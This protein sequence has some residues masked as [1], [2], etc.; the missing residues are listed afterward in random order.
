MKKRLLI[1]AGAMMSLALNAQTI[2][3]ENFET[4]NA[5]L[6]SGDNFS[7]FVDISTNVCGEAV[8]RDLNP[9]DS[10]PTPFSPMVVT[11][12]DETGSPIFLDITNNQKVT[13]GIRAAAGL[14]IRMNYVSPVVVDGE[15][16][17]RLRDNSRQ[18]V[19]TEYELEELVFD[20]TNTTPRTSWDPTMAQRLFIE[21]DPI[22]GRTEFSGGLFYV[23]YIVIGDVDPALITPSVCSGTDDTQFVFG[24]GSSYY[25]NEFTDPSILSFSGMNLNHLVLDTVAECGKVVLTDRDDTVAISA[26]DPILFSTRDAN[27]S[28]QDIDMTGNTKVIVRAKAIGGDA[29]I[30]VDLRSTATGNST[31]G[32][33]ARI[34]R[35][36]P[37]GE[38]T[39]AEYFF[40]PSQL[41]DIDGNDVDI[42]SVNGINMSFGQDMGGIG[43]D[44]IIFDFVSFGEGPI[45]S[46]I[47]CVNAVNNRNEIQ[48]LGFYPN[49]VGSTV[50]IESASRGNLTV[51]NQYG[52][53]VKEVKVNAPSE[54][55]SLEEL[56]SG[57]YII[58]LTTDSGQI[59]TN[60]FVKD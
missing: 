51:V 55:I 1:V 38:W 56:E 40:F 3:T 16:T 52:T 31:N 13:M 46:D 17:P 4:G 26:T 45:D 9:L 37:Q 20:F 11:F 29:S 48:T 60:N 6:I 25:V 41:K 22:S 2:Y 12:R 8:I 49:P 43:A 15:Q 44:S 28:T 58:K 14:Q 53:L 47:A 19:Q 34:R 42:T 39:T 50:T 7:P 32:G 27:G 21:V 24:D 30:R 5:D 33:Q 36:F 18:T 23:D 54:T 59:F 35:T 57:L 10:S